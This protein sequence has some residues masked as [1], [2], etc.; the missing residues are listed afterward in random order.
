[1]CKIA[2]ALAVLSLSL[3]P[4]AAG[5]CV[6]QCGLTR[7]PAEPQ[8]PVGSRTVCVERTVNGH[9]VTVCTTEEW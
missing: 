5:W 3:S 7:V 6:E 1:M 2:I 8:Q 4:A 9:S